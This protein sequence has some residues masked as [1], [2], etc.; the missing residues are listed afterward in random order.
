LPKIVSHVLEADD[1]YLGALG[2]KRPR[3][4]RGGSL[5][6][7][8]DWMLEALDARVHDRPFAVPRNTKKP[9]SPRY[10]VR[11]S[12]WHALDHAWEIEDRARTDR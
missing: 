5:A 8:H 12:A 7:L 6:D 4:M 9:W 3:E 10:F 2:A 11:R 1:A